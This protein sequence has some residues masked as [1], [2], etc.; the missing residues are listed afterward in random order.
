LILIIFYQRSESLRL[1]GI[2]GWRLN[3]IESECRAESSCFEEI[4]R[5]SWSSGRCPGGQAEM[6]KNFGNHRRVF[7][8]GDDLQGA[9]TVQAVFIWIN[10][11]CFKWQL[12]YPE[13]L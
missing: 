8:H 2:V 9:A 3:R 7:T 13:K 1:Q 4:D 10:S 6:S 12:N 5:P 11:S